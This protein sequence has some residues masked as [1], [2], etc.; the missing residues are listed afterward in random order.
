VD[1]EFSTVRASLPRALPKLVRVALGVDRE[2]Q[3]SWSQDPYAPLRGWRDAVEALGVLVMQQGPVAVDEMRGF[4]SIEPE[5]LPAILLNSKD[6]PRA[7]AFTL[8]HELGHLALT[9]NVQ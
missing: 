9:R 7:R 8:L 4:A 1:R 6:D 5:S 3:Q 2:A